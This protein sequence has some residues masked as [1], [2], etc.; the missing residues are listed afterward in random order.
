LILTILA[1]LPDEIPDLGNAF[2]PKL[3]ESIVAIGLAATGILKIWNSFSQKSRNVTGG[4]TQ[5]TTDGSLAKPGTQ[6]LVDATAAAP[7]AK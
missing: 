2:S 6:T 7:A 4:N 3:K 5:Q 1:G